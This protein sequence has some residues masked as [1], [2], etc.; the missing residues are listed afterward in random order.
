MSEEQFWFVIINC[1][2]IEI[3]ETIGRGALLQGL[4]RSINIS[5]E[6]RTAYLWE[7]RIVEDREVQLICKTSE[8]LRD[9][10][11]SFAK[12]AHSFEAPSIIALPITEVD[13]TYRQFLAGNLA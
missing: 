11:F 9:A 8:A 7:G 5:A 2:S 10:L 3:A 12:E 13:P 6:M 1:P 4:S